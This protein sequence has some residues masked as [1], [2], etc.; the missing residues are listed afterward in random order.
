[1]PWSENAPSSEVRPS[2]SR[3]PRQASIASFR[4]RFVVSA[5]SSFSSMDATQGPQT[6]GAG[7][8]V[9]DP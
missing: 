6:S 4:R 3:S 1:M 9:V 2:I 8:G 7:M 5:S